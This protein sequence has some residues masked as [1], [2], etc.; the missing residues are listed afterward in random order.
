MPTTSW[1]LASLFLQAPC[2]VTPSSNCGSWTADAPNSWN[3]SAIVFS[4]LERIKVTRISIWATKFRL[5]NSKMILLWLIRTIRPPF[6]LR[7]QQSDNQYRNSKLKGRRL[8]M[9]TRLDHRWAH[10]N[11]PLSIWWCLIQEPLFI[12]QVL[13]SK[14]IINSSMVS[15]SSFHSSNNHNT[16]KHPLDNH[17][18][19]SIHLDKLLWVIHNMASRP[20]SNMGSH[21]WDNNQCTVSHSLANSAVGVL[22]PSN[23]NNNLIIDTWLQIKMLIISNE[24]T[25]DN[26]E[27]YHLIFQNL[28]N[29]D[30]NIIHLN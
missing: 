1:D 7:N 12:I 27:S 20:I 11:Y 29:L 9:C 14:H 15:K 4:K 24:I 26:G 16:V 2:P 6:M 22:H 8:R 13:A 18:R 30:I 21:P 17:H 25:L 3:A 19:E 10:S 23:I 5:R 28:L